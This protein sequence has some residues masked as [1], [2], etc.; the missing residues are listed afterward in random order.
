[1]LIEKEFHAARMKIIDTTTPKQDFRFNEWTSMNRRIGTH[2]MVVMME[3]VHDHE[4]FSKQSLYKL[5]IIDS[6]TLNLHQSIGVDQLLERVH[7]VL[8]C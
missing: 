8:V 5:E 2:C 4:V 6:S 7:Q 1:M 3:V